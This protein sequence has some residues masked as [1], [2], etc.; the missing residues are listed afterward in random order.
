MDGFLAHI[1]GRAGATY[2]R[3]ARLL[4]LH[5]AGRGREKKKPTV[6]GGAR[7]EEKGATATPSPDWKVN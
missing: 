5:G 1:P 4:R 6:R 2:G 3:S 7:A